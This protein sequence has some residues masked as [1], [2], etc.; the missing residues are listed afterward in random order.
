MAKEWH[1]YNDQFDSARTG[2]HGWRKAL[3]DAAPNERESTHEAAPNCHKLCRNGLW[4]IPPE[5]CQEAISGDPGIG[6]WG[7]RRGEHSNSW[8]TVADGRMFQLVRWPSWF[9]VLEMQYREHQPYSWI[10]GSERFPL[11][12]EWIGVQSINGSAN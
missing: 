2:E 1:Y 7:F 12:A 9:H 6:P 10:P 8:Y 3:L 4:P 5:L 11:K